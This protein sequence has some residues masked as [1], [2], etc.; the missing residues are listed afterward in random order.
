[1]EFGR[2]NNLASF[3]GRGSGG[4]QLTQRSDRGVADC[5]GG[6]HCHAC[7][8]PD[9]ECETERGFP[10]TQSSKSLNGR[11]RFMLVLLHGRSSTQ[12]QMALPGP[13]AKRG[14]PSTLHFAMVS[15]DCPVVHRFPGFCRN[16]AE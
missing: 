16:T 10:T 2:G 12:N 4:R 15:G 7:C 3:H 8:P 6:H 13:M 11:T 14:Q 1:M 9:E 5:R